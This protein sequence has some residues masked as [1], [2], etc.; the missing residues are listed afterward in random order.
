MLYVQTTN[1]KG[2][3]LQETIYQAWHRLFERYSAILGEDN[4]RDLT[5]MID[6]ANQRLEA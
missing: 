3:Q 2:H 4:S 5:Q 6:E 1:E